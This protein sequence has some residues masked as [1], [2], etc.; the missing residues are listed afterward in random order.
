MSNKVLDI[1]LGNKTPTGSLA[2]VSLPVGGADNPASSPV[3]FNNTPIIER[4]RS[5]AINMQITA[6]DSIMQE[7]QRIIA[8]PIIP[9]PTEEEIKIISNYYCPDGR[10]DFYPEQAKAIMQY[11]DFGGQIAPVCVG[12]G[13]T[14]ISVLIANDAY[15]KFG[16]RRIMLMNPP[17][18]IDQ[19]RNTELPL[20]RRHMSIN[21][22]FYWI[23]SMSPKKRMLQ[24]KSKRSGVYVVSYSLLSGRKGAE[25]IDAIEPDLIIGD[26]I[27]KIA[28]ANPS[29][30]G[31]RFKEAVQKFSPQIVGLSGTITKKTPRDYH[32]LISHALQ[33][34]CPM[35]RPVALADEW[36]KLIDSG[37]SSIDEF[38]NNSAPQLIPFKILIDWAK[39]NFPDQ[40]KNYPN[41]LI[42][43]RAAYKTRLRTCPGVVASDGEDLGVSLRITNIDSN[44]KHEYSTTI[45][46]E[47]SKGWEK[48]TEL[49]K[50][51]TDLWIAPNGDEIDHAMHMWRWRFELEGFGFFNNLF[52][53]TPEKIA[54][55]KKISDSEARDIIDR[56]IC[57]HLLQQEYHRILRSWIS[58]R[59]KKGL[60]T[61][62]LIGGE[63]AR[64]QGELVGQELFKAWSQMKAAVFSGMIER[65][66][67]FVR[68]C[69]F[70][71]KR[72]IEWAKTWHKNRSDKAAIVWYVNNGVAEWLRDAF[73]EADLPC[74]YC[75]AGKKGKANLEDRTQG[76][77]FA[78]ASLKAYN[79]GLN[80][81]YHHD[82]EM[83]AQWP[84]EAILAQQGMG[85]VHRNEQASD[86]V[87]I[88]GSF[89]SEFDR[90]NFAA[91][92]NDS[93][94][95]HQT[96]QK[97]KLLYADY[98]ERPKVLP[99]SV[100][101]EW[102]TQAVM[103]DA[104][105]RRLLEDTFRGE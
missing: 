87:R 60:D 70:R 98:D 44:E 53:P 15:T 67:E 38:P 57:H 52:W 28:S 78:I 64:N 55:R 103:L 73:I 37:A 43:F 75:P 33:E 14:L 9:E 102:G 92:L 97:Q 32:F 90:I 19:L 36:A 39:K 61:P 3:T 93:A 63:M 74:L 35:P 66:K 99:H 41:N 48:L 8:L 27:H 21:V 54:L 18:L 59:A 100:L 47:E 62:F 56:S 40:A 49:V 29:A 76:D 30:R 20:Y 51:L 4:F 22:P 81:Q 79:E 2:P 96:T 65:D 58:R 68:V 45:V 94:Y 69:D 86:E 24:A 50:Q 88:F 101:M 6:N 12:G 11:H 105:R 23:A 71:I 84:R 82:T 72:I 7:I 16:K 13:K 104:D 34:N 17:N 1:L 42:G 25:I 91:C 85:R 83:F 31:R 46:N 10:F 89:N 26:E 77:K 95:I 5:V 80:L